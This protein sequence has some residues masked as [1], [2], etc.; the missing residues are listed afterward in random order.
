[1]N[2]YIFTLVLLGCISVVHTADT[3]QDTSAQPHLRT[4]G[5][6]DSAESDDLW[7]AFDELQ[8]RRILAVERPTCTAGC[9]ASFVSSKACEPCFS[10]KSCQ[11][12]NKK[13]GTKYCH[14][15]CLY[16]RGVSYRM[17][18]QGNKLACVPGCTVKSCEGELSGT[19]VSSLFTAKVAGSNIQLAWKKDYFRTNKVRLCFHN[20][21]TDQ[22]KKLSTKSEQFTDK[23]GLVKGRRYGY[24]LCET[25]KRFPRCRRAVVTF[26]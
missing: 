19:E 3:I 10:P 1:M 25:G 4:Q 5:E 2:S 6:S 14:D 12:V 21:H 16:D 17:W 18:L 20:M 7:S 15:G 13:L 26:N 24:R 22:C 8:D 23:R 11:Q 9:I